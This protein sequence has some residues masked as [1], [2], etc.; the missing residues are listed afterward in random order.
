MNFTIYIQVAG[1]SNHIAYDGG[2]FDVTA[3]VYEIPTVSRSLVVQ[4]FF[5]GVHVEGKQ[6]NS[7]TSLL[8]HN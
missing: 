1:L 8:C 6:L 2:W 7:D 3:G 5:W 4:D